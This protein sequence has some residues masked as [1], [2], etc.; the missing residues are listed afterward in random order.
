MNEDMKAFDAFE[1]PL[2]Y[3]VTKEVITI[4]D[5]DFAT[6]YIDT[7]DHKDRYNDKIVEYDGQVLF[8]KL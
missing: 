8:S 1:E 4:E 7:F 6:F 2:P 5:R 3:D